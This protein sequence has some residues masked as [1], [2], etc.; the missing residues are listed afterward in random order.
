MVKKIFLWLL[1][2]VSIN[3]IFGTDLFE[4]S[5]QDNSCSAGF[6]EVFSGNGHFQKDGN[7]LSS[8]VAKNS[9]L[10]NYNKVL[11]CKVNNEN[12][13]NV[14][15]DYMLVNETCNGEEL[16]Y[17]TNSTNAR[18]AISKNSLEKSDY[19][20]NFNESYYSHKL[21]VEIPDEFSSL[22]ILASDY[23]NFK[24]AGYSC[25]FKTNSLINGLVSDCNAKYGSS[26]PVNQYQYTI[27]AKL[28]ENSESLKCNSD[29]TSVL[30]NRVYSECSQKITECVGIPV[31][32]DGSLYGS[33]VKVSPTVEVKCSASWDEKRVN[34]FTEDAIIVDST[35]TCKNVVKKKYTT[36]FDNNQVTMDIYICEKGDN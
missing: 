20:M 16:I 25:L 19:I 28:W 12:I 6:E 17:F 35:S 33:W 21:C 34:K 2:L 31:E 9:D 32:C 14:K 7:L 23:E 8:N 30:D 4:C 24:Y 26:A 36:M 13:Q 27:W 11:C 18:T 22:D 5:F 3:S 10:T 29:C 15:F 1:I